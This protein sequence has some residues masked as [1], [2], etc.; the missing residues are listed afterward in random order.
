MRIFA[1]LLKQAWGYMHETQRAPW[2]LNACLPFYRNGTG[3]REGWAAAL[4]PSC[5]CTQLQR[6]Q[7][8]RLAVLLAV[9]ATR[10][11]ALAGAPLFNRASLK[12]AGAGRGIWA[13]PAPAT[14][15]SASA[16]E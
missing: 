13:R 2:D 14:H 12:P 4:A 16:A 7:R 8:F 11:R 1:S 3:G 10:Q 9:Q 5:Q 15:P 6:Q